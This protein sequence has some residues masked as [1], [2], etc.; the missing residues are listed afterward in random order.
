MSCLPGP[1][2]ENA[3][4][5]GRKARRAHDPEIEALATAAVDCGYRVHR[6][7]GPGLLEK[8]YEA[9]LEDCLRCK[10]LFVERQ[11]PVDV[12]FEGRVIRD[13]LVIDLLVERRLIIEVKSTEKYVP[14]HAKQVLTY[15]RLTDNS[16]GLLMN[17]GAETFRDGFK[18]VPNNYYGHWK[19]DERT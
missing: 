15:L 12:T 18:R 3:S 17:F 8:V 5:E 16:L 9:I 14:V 19:T 10:G 2:S 11:K 1:E 6:A 7:L 13:G 4:Q